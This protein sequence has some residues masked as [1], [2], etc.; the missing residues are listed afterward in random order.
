M[1]FM[2]GKKL[3]DK[4][5]CTPTW[6]YSRVLKVETDF[7]ARVHILEGRQRQLPAPK[8]STSTHNKNSKIGRNADLLPSFQAKEKRKNIIILYSP[9][10]KPNC[11]TA[12]QK[13]HISAQ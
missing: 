3:P 10:C 12:R 5:T 7:D 13:I 1:H 11:T 4:S 2:N 8:T 6:F 9:K